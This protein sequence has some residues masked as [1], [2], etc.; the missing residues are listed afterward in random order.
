M[1]VV[2]PFYLRALR[3]KSIPTP[4]GIYSQDGQDVFI[5]TEFYSAICSPTF[6]RTFVDVGCN[7]P[8]LYNNS[9]FFEQILGFRVVA[10][11]AI[12]SYA[13][14]WQSLRPGATFVHTAVGNEVG[15]VEFEL[16]HGEGIQNMYSSV[17]GASEKNRLMSRITKRV[18]IT[19]LTKVLIELGIADIGIMS[20]D[21]E[22]FEL[23]AIE[24][25]DFSQIKIRII[26]VE[27]NSDG[28]LGGE[29][30][31][32]VLNSNGYFFYARIWGLDDI[33]VHQ[34]LC[35]ELSRIG[36]YWGG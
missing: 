12:D 19:T 22:G 11:D 1:I 4:R 31:R 10:I 15:E 35:A 24:G 29:S 36:S 28:L 2:G 16:A 27:N 25:I 17:R 26:V 33:F 3:L 34:S 23:Q 21:I 14:E 32:S 8:L 9:A 5:L 13:N 20:L 30:I 7:Q 6:P 18:P